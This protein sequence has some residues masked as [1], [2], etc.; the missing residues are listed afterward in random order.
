MS[1]EEKR[2]LMAE[3]LLGNDN[4]PILKNNERRTAKLARSSTTCHYAWNSLTA[5]SQ[6]KSFPPKFRARE[7]IQFPFLERVTFLSIDIFSPTSR[8]SK[9]V[10][11][12]TVHPQRYAIISY[13]RFSIRLEKLIALLNC[14]T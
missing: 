14:N 6:L 2:T 4:Y 9:L 7:Q 1:K 13:C 5:P 11:S 8:H 12:T 10:G 3:L